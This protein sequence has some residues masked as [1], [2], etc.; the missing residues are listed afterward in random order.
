V[1]FWDCDDKPDPGNYLF[2]SRQMRT[3]ATEIGVGDFEF[4]DLRSRKRVNFGGADLVSEIT[5]YPGLWRMIFDR[6]KINLPK[7]R[8]FR[9]AED[10]VFLIE[11]EFEKRKI[12]RESVVVYKY[13]TNVPGQLTR[14]HEAI[15]DT[16]LAL[17]FL[18]SIYFKQN[19]NLS[20][21]RLLVSLIAKQILSA[22]KHRILAGDLVR[23]FLKSDFWSVK[24]FKRLMVLLHQI[25]I[26]LMQKSMR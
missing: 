10:Q 24:N 16:N 12:L 21:Q 2:L 18:L 3:Q 6:D 9:M 22:C 23:L 5:S 13:E 15:S 26:Q 1:T 19:S 8:D 4:S 7:F 25:G 20:N 11:I 17:K 14:S